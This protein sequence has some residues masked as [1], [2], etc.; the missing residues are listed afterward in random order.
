MW[1]ILP[2]V[3]CAIHTKFIFLK[4]DAVLE[5]TE[6]SIKCTYKSLSKNVKTLHI[7]N[8]GSWDI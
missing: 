4:M 1:P 2:R 3:I 6:N 5:G 8:H 7:Y